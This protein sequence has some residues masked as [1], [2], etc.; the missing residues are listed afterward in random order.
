MKKVAAKPLTAAQ[1]VDLD[2][3]AALPDDQIDTSNMPEQRDW[4]G[5][6]RGQFYRPIKQQITLRIDVDVIAWFRQHATTEN[7]YQTQINT[8]LREYVG[9][10]GKR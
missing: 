10:R 5:A 4:R 1:R 3:L 6:Q 9:R 7:G 8:A 2:A